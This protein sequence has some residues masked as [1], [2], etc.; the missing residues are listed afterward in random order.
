M[1]EITVFL[2]VFNGGAYLE[3]TLASLQAQDFVP[4]EVLCID[5]CSTDGS[6]SI[7]QNLAAQ[8]SRFHYM[9]PDQNLGSASRAIQFAAPRAKGK[10]FVYSS[11]DDLFSPDWLSKLHQ[12]A[13]SGGLDAVLP[14]VEFYH[15]GKTDNRRLCGLNGSLDA[16][17]S[18]R[19]ALIA[20]LDWS[21]PGNAL[22][23]ISFLET[24][25]FAD[26][27]AFSDEFSVRRFF[28][29]CDKIGFC[30]GIFYYRQDNSEAITKVLKP[31][32]LDEVAANFEVW[33][34]LKESAFERETLGSFAY[35]TLRSLIRAQS[36]VFLAPQLAGHENGLHRLWSDM[37]QAGLPTDL[38]FAPALQKGKIRAPLYMRAARSWPWLRALARVSSWSKRLKRR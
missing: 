22:W 1:P 8:D 17:I 37:K 33:K 13:L 28:L 2:P 18:G 31:A 30:D 36:F 14:Q 21:I 27:G 20:S 10:R 24:P 7:L 12:R 6:A 23:P 25:G 26:L 34:L 16:V 5:D 4:F 9:R 19:E 11:Q 32:R 15:E 38:A 35:R 3:R 29:A